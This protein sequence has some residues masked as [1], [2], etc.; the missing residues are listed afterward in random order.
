M[1]RRLN[2]FAVLVS[3]I[4]IFFV[5]PQPLQFIFGFFQLFLLPGLAFFLLI[6]F[7]FSKYD[8][9]FYSILISPVLLSILIVLFNIITE[10][11]YFSLRIVLIAFYLTYLVIFFLNN[12]NN[13]I[14]EDDS[15]IPHAVFLVSI[16]YGFLILIS[17]F[18][19][20]FLL[21]RSDA[22]YHAA[23]TNEVI[24]RG[25][26]PGEPF[27]AS[28][29][30]QYMWFY[31]LFNACWIK[32][33]GLSLFWAPG[34][35]NVINAIVFPY[36]IARFTLLFTD[37]KYIIIPV[38]ILSIV[39]LQAASWILW[40]LN[41][42]RSLI[43]DVTGMAEIERIISKIA[44]NGAGVVRF[45]TPFGTWQVQLIDKFLTITVF[46]YSLNLFMACIILILSKK[47]FDI[48][49]YRTA[50]VLFIL[51]LGTFLFHIVTG[52]VLLSAIVGSIILI[53]LAIRFI[54]KKVQFQS[55]YLLLIIIPL[56]VA[57]IAIPYFL[58]LVPTSQGDGS[59]SFIK[60]YLHFGIKNILTILF[61]L[62]ILFYPARD[63]F[64][65]LFAGR[66][67][68]TLTLTY[69]IISLFILCAFIN[70]GTVGEKKLIYPLFLLL[71][72]LVF[73]QIINRIINYS[74]VK[75]SLWII[76]ILILFLLP[77]VFIFRGFI[78]HSPDNKM[79]SERYD[80]TENEKEIYEWIK[81]N[82]SADAVIIEN[83]IYHMAPVYAGRRNFFSWHH[84]I[85]NRNFE[86]KKLSLYRNIQNALYN[87]QDLP[88]K[89]T[90]HLLNFEYPLYIILRNE[91]MESHPWLKDR[92][93]R[94]SGLFEKIHKA[95]RIQLYTLKDQNSNFKDD[96]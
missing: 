40:P 45:L 64:K 41:L 42:A 74:S 44:I 95:G 92:F 91:D 71:G 9:I 93:D 49:R 34:I 96:L 90:R 37:R 7:G 4:S 77:A 62:I 21:I 15:K 70:I 52:I 85:T 22:W 27:L 57:A 3:S 46:N 83:N 53:Y 33:S 38:C 80:I 68:K 11:I 30:I 24:Q 82:T 73:L 31:H 19:N 50:L 2:L 72:P 87:Q 63:A 5:L 13:K 60:K 69:L 25:I 67:Y 26:P 65:K 55:E 17:Y 61:P 88:E 94:E 78:I 51:I 10:D 23:V 56:L 1:Y 29:S 43:G 86:G 39:G 54:Y 28:F 20:D 79:E 66:D 84:V 59:G 14:I 6:N 35:F 36:L 18:L 8:R 47:L 32:Q 81:N 48:A 75:K 76:G 58:S 16:F 89:A 12:R